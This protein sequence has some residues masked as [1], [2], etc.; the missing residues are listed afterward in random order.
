[1]R[2]PPKQ[3][4]SKLFLSGHPGSNDTGYSGKNMALE[5]KSWLKSET[6]TV[7]VGVNQIIVDISGGKNDYSTKCFRLMLLMHM[8]FCW[9]VL[10]VLA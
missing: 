8:V 7:V 10:G 3:H 6:K 2:C 1:M 5:H 4:I 9:L